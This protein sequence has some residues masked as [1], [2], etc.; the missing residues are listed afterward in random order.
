[1]KKQLVIAMALLFTANISAFAQQ[2]YKAKF[3][4]AFTRYMDW[5]DQAKQGLFNIGVYGSID[6]YKEISEETMGR[7]VGNQNIVAINILK[8]NQL[9]LAKLHILVVGR[10]YCTPEHLRNITSKFSNSYTLIITEDDGIVNG[11]GISFKNSGQSL[12]FQYNLANIKSKGIATSR[13]FQ[14]MGEGVSGGR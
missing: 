8:E 4:N 13:Q 6:L 5:P 1:M 12:S 9:E 11:A 10:K 2:S 7:T 14:G 3:I